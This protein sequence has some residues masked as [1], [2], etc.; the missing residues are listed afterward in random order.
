M[1]QGFEA[2]KIFSPWF[3][4]KKVNP[5]VGSN[6]K[7]SEIPDCS[8][9]EMPTNVT[10]SKQ[11][12]TPET[13]SS[14]YYIKVIKKPLNFLNLEDLQFL[15]EHYPELNDLKNLNDLKDRLNK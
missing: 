2:N 4:G 10:S 5:D 3:T 7:K 1:Q 8:F 6:E 12:T 11:E 15:K 9:E 13:I 14:R